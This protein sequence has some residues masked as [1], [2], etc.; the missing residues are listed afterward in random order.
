[1]RRPIFPRKRVKSNLMLIL[2]SSD[3][4]GITESSMGASGLL[5]FSQRA[6]ICPVVR[7][8]DCHAG[9]IIRQSTAVELSNHPE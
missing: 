9:V 6:K 5:I 4:L 8:L 3:L 7:A 2:D 1:M